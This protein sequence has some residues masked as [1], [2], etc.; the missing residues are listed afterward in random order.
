MV[1]STKI[2]IGCLPADTVEDEIR[3]Y[4]LSFCRNLCKMKIKYRSNSI[5]AGYGNFTARLTKK[6]L[7]RLTNQRHVYRGRILECRPYLKGKK[8]ES[9]L[10]QFNSKRIYVEN[11]PEGTTDASLYRFFSGICNVERAYLANNPDKEGGIFGFVI[12]DSPKDTDKVLGMKEI[13]LRGSVLTVASSICHK[14][15]NMQKKRHLKHGKRKT[16]RGDTEDYNQSPKAQKNSHGKILKTLM[17]RSKRRANK[18]HKKTGVTL[19]LKQ[20][21]LPVLKHV[22]DENLRFNEKQ[23][24]A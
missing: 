19:V 5:C 7:S 3:E 20:G 8:L 21:F 16:E 1:R 14:L 11:I 23:I 13:R 2:F 18:H 4:F 10:K 9:Y 6:E 24:S 15:E 22:S 17:M 12:T